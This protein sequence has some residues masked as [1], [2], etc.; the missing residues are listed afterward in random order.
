MITIDSEKLTHNAAADILKYI[1][2]HNFIRDFDYSHSR[3]H[4]GGHLFIDTHGLPYIFDILKTHNI[5]EADINIEDEFEHMW[6]NLSEEEQAAYT[7][8]LCETAPRIKE[9]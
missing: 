8:K 4:K 7:K 5:P 1:G 9:P 2:E 6:N 3:E